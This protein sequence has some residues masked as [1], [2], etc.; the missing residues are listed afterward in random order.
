[1]M[2]RT[3]VNSNIQGNYNMKKLILN[4]ISKYYAK[5][6]IVPTAYVIFLI[7]LDVFLPINM[8]N[9]ILHYHYT[10][11]EASITKIYNDGDRYIKL[12]MHD[13]YFTGYNKYINGQVV[14]YYYYTMMGPDN[15]IC[16]IVLLSPESCE[17]G[18]PII[19]YLDELVEISYN[20]ES[21][22]D[23]LAALSKDLGWSIDGMTSVVSRYTLSQPDATSIITFLL[24]YGYYISLFYSLFSIILCGTCCIF[25]GISP[26]IL[27]LVPYKGNRMDMVKSAEKE[28][29]E[30]QE[31]NI[32]DCFVTEN[33]FILISAD[34]VAIAPL[35]DIL[36][37]YKYSK[38]HKLIFYTFKISYTLFITTKSGYSIKCPRILRSDLD[39]LMDHLKKK[40]SDILLGFTEENRKAASV[41]RKNRKNK[42]HS[43]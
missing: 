4:S 16:R 31:L 6:M 29:E 7:L 9:L 3:T 28:L 40:N 26:P 10:D 30:Q 18:K 1:M 17:H 20:S 43:S 21:T 5:R 25:P 27:R 2:F 19:D 13:L 37:I 24:G 38:L 32:N 15:D 23:M 42:G 35:D 33:F 34:G 8:S 36:W 39:I 41:Y 22:Y 12:E 14:G 11:A